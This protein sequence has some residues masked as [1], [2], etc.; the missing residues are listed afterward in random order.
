MS[1]LGACQTSLT[2]VLVSLFHGAI[3]EQVWTGG[4]QAL[5]LFGGGVSRGWL[6]YGSEGL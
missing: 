3:L 6:V 1:Q 2:G 5:L 4:G